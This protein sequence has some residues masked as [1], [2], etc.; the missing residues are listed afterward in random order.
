MASFDEIIKL[1]K[2]P[3]SIK[4]LALISK[5]YHFAEKAHKDQKRF[6]G[7][8]YFLHLTETAKILADL[9]K[10]PITIA[11]GLLHDSI[12]DVG[13]QDKDIE[14]HFGKEV[15]FLVQGVTK[16]GQLRYRGVE[17]HIDS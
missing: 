8:P 9:G 11:A 3:P 1:L 15:L 10:G 17:R 16:L 2:E 13:V 5:A 4:D 7:D 6:S 14:K 12:E